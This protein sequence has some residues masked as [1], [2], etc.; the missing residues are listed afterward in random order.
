MA[1]EKIFGKVQMREDVADLADMRNVL[2]NGALTVSSFPDD[3]VE[4]M[5]VQLVMKVDGYIAGHYYKYLEVDSRLTWVDITAYMA[6]STT[7]GA[8]EY[9]YNE[10]T[11][12]VTFSIINPASNENDAPLS[13]TIF[14]SVDKDKDARVIEEQEIYIVGRDASGS[15]PEAV[16]IMVALDDDGVSIN[17][18]KFMVEFVFTDGTS[19]RCDCVFSS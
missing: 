14:Y 9:T 7:V 1:S 18:M 2:Q 17:D 8:C 16:E 6:K 11:R 12:E 4:G 3:A 13:K 15:V 10:D 19:S 5:I